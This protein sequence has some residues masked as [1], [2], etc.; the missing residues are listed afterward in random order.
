VLIVDVGRRVACVAAWAIFAT[1]VLAARGVRNFYPLSVFDMYQAHA[2][3]VVARVLVIDATGDTAQIEDFEAW[4]CAPELVLR[5]VDRTCGAEHR[6][7]EY[8]TRDQELYVHAHRGEA[9][10][11]ETVTVVSRAYVLR[12]RAGEPAQSD[13]TIARCTATRREGR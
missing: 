1:Y 13:C 2:P 10:G 4:T 6:P 5:D 8:V 3:D 9:P 11:S 12:P 7:L